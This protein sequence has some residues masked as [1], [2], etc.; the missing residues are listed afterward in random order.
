MTVLVFRKEQ[1]IIEGRAEDREE[2]DDRLR[3]D[4]FL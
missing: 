4:F 3:I 1:M 2:G